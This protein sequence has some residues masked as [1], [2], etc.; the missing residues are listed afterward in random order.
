MPLATISKKILC[1]DMLPFFPVS[2]LENL[3]SLY[4]PA[5]VSYYQVSRI[6][7]YK[8][9]TYI[10]CTRL[11]FFNVCGVFISVFINRL[12]W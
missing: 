1:L 3:K 2:S 12:C 7:S 11:V 9:S 5:S 10:N 8:C 4:L 6:S